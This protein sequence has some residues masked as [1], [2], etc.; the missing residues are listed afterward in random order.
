[1][2]SKQ[3]SVI[4]PRIILLLGFIVLL[5]VIFFNKSYSSF[6][7]DLPRWSQVLYATGT[8]LLFFFISYISNRKGYKI[9]DRLTGLISLLPW[10]GLIEIFV[11]IFLVLV[12]FETRAARLGIL[13]NYWLSG[14]SF[15]NAYQ[16]III[17]LYPQLINEE[18]RTPPDPINSLPKNLQEIMNKG[19][20]SIGMTTLGTILVGN[21]II[22][23]SVFFLIDMKYPLTILAIEIIAVIIITFIVRYFSILK[24]QKQAMQSEIPEK[25]LKS[26]A[27]LAGLPW[28]NIKEK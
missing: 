17:Y 10:F 6:V 27:K 24:W 21:F 1:M 9:I 15:L 28:L 22:L 25:E 13:I 7:L 26:A 20:Q 4:V 12:D 16:I 8:A 19:K 23:A 2:N 3:T 11:A 5:F 18:Q 14:I